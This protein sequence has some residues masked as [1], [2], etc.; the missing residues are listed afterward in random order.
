MRLWPRSTD[1]KSATL[2]AI[3]LAPEAG[4]PVVA[5]AKATVGEAGLVGD[6]YAAQKGFWR[7]P[8]A[9]PITL[10]RAEDLDLIQRR[11]HLA[12]TAG[13]HRRNLVVR[14]LPSR[15]LT[16]GVLVLGD[17][18]L[19][20][21][22]PRPPCLYLERLTQRGMGRALRKSGGVCARIIQ[23]GSLHAGMAIHKEHTERESP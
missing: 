12:V 9:C 3:F 6:R 15:Q 2:E 11:H 10:I 5:V 14:G 7:G 23:P 8:D 13:E 18:R 19:R 20:L 21:T 16:D 4:A 22:V 17:V 1:K